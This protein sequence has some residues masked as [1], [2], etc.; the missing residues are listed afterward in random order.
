MNYCYEESNLTKLP[1]IVGPTAVGKSALGL[2]WAQAAGGEIISGD[3]V[4]VYKGF[5]IGSAKPT[6]EERAAVPHHLIDIL[7]PGEPFSAAHFQVLARGAVD[8]I[9]RRH[10]QPIVVGGTGLYIRALLDPFDFP[11]EGSQAVKKKWAELE[12]QKGSPYLHAQLKEWD[13]ESAHKLHV[14]DKARIIRALEVYELTQIPLSQ[15]RAYTE[16]HYPPLEN[17]VFVG[18][19]IERSVMY[20]RIENRCDAM[21]RAGLIEEAETLLRQGCSPCLKPMRS[22]GYRHV[23][24]YLY[25][26]A[27]KQEMMRLFKRDTRRFAKRQLTWFKRDPRITW[28]N[29]H[30]LSEKQIL[31]ALLNS[32]IVENSHVE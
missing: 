18:L 5:T 32:C 30:Y 1:V 27:T 15:Q 13:P 19:E 4:Q 6:L 20:Q 23:T 8:D 14:N 11:Q 22:I 26:K 31:N 12:K 16:K 17:V 21:I 3:S 24:D 7:E 10:R 29:M 28:Y 2:L 25:G 9:R